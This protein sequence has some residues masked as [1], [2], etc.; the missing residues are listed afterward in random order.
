MT[1]PTF[2]ETEAKKHCKR[3]L[4]SKTAK[5]LPRHKA[6][7]LVILAFTF[8]AAWALDRPDMIELANAQIDAR[9]AELQ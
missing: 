4:D 9:K 8:G 7:A 3:L 5:I 1:D 6:E 2:V